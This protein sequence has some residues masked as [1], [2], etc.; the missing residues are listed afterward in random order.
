LDSGLPPGAYRIAI[1]MYDPQ[2]GARLAVSNPDGQIVG[3]RILL[4]SPAQMV[5]K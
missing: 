2:T 4:P 1:G 5:Q 3:D